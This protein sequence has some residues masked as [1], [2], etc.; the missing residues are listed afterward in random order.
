[1]KKNRVSGIGGILF[2]CREP[3]ALKAWYGKH[4]GLQTDRYGTS[5]EFRHADD[6]Q[7]KGFLQ[8]S[9]MPE[10][11]TYFE[12]SKAPFMINYRVTDLEALV[13]GSR[14][15]G[16]TVLDEIETFDYG[17]FVHILDPEGHKIEL[18]EPVDEVYDDIAEARTK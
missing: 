15:A 17:K 3:E 5:F 11:S 10:N 13:E 7:R 4:L 16:V 1:M 6:P 9:P 12:P 18:W 14:K 2:R 8:W